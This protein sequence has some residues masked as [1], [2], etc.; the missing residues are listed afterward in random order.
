MPDG[1]FGFVVGCF[2]CY[3]GCCFSVGQVVLGVVV[4]VFV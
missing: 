2:S 3:F 4:A 1:V